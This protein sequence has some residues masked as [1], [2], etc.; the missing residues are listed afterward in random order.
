MQ[1]VA[2]KLKASMLS[3][4]KQLESQTIETN[5]ALLQVSLWTKGARSTL[6]H[7]SNK[8]Q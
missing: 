7:A 8:K 6:K 2:R 3:H 5:V 1:Y 4:K